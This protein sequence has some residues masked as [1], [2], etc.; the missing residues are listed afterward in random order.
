MLPI[1]SSLAHFSPDLN[2]IENFWGWMVKRMTNIDPANEDE[3]WD[4]VF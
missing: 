4:W 1:V 3:L 2:P